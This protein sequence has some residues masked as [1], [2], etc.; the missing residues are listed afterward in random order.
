MATTDAP[1]T[2]AVSRAERTA[3]CDLLLETGPDAPTLCAGWTTRDLAAHL[4]I[5][6]GRP[7]AAMGIVVKQL[8]GWTE[9]VQAGAAQR[10]YAD[11]IST[12]RSGPPRWSMMAIPSVDAQSNTIEYFIHH[13]DVR[14]GG[15]QWEPRE[16]DEATAT[17]LWERVSK[18]GKFFTRR[19]TVG[20]VVAPTDGPG[21]GSELRIKDG[22][23]SVTLRG[24]VGEIVMAIYGRVTRGLEI[25]GAPADVEAF[26]TYPR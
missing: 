18:A 21:A 13:E 12:V 14:R 26:L 6:E 8:A 9:K 1:A 7:D 16:L 19:S 3:L 22:D 25:E 5:R 4:V 23:T 15:E 11:L 17:D 2:N 24:P 10:P 20:V